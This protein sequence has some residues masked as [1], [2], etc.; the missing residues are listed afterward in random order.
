MTYFSTTLFR[1]TLFNLQSKLELDAYRIPVLS[2]TVKIF[3]NYLWMCVCWG[4]E[5]VGE[6]VD[7]LCPLL[8]YNTTSS[9][10]FCKE[11][12]AKPFLGTKVKG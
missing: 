7:K 10:T 12:K 8:K 3:K 11:I 9:L 1:T 2:I 5:G 4:R 6:F